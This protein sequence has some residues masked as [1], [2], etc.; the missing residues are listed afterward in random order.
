MG[1]DGR[2]GYVRLGAAPIPIGKL[3]QQFDEIYKSAVLQQGAWERRI[4]G[5][6]I[7]DSLRL[8]DD[9]MISFPAVMGVVNVTPDS[10]SDGGRYFDADRATAHAL[11][12]EAA[13]ASIIDI[14]AESSRPA[15][16]REVSADVELARL[17]PVL[18][19]LGGELKV[20]LSIDTRKPE[21]ARIALDSGA[22]IINDITAL[23]NEGMA[24]LA[25]E[26]R[27]AVV[28]MHMKGS[29]EDHVRFASYRN[30]V[31][32]VMTFLTER[33]AFA[34]ASGIE[35][36]RIILDPG[37]GFAK[38]AHH[39]LAILGNLER[40]CELGYPV[41]I[42]ASRKNFIS[43][44]AGKRNGDLLLGTNA[45]NAV[46][47]AAGAAIIRVHDPAPAAVTARIAAAIAAARRA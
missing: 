32:E 12:M 9:R 27:C 26:R 30:V 41:L 47:V 43:T 23:S 17:M 15:G 10:F 24:A 1:G 35:R 21:V 20:P 14:G 16:A 6:V 34:L 44:I 25:A 13:G 5:P 40:L 4:V 33:A 8:H 18:E 11:E 28:L 42:G 31:D 7:R 19:R 3:R 2:D 38:T 45:V 37:L 22:A 36:S 39:N 29:L 46:A